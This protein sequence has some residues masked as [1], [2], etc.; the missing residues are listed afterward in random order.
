MPF[1]P[2][3]PPRSHPRPLPPLPFR[4]L[5]LAALAMALAWG[6]RTPVASPPVPPS[7]SPKPT[8]VR[9]GFTLQAG[10]FAKVEN[11]A[12]L[13]ER[14]QSE[15][16]D[17]T[18]F[19]APDGLHKVRFGDFPTREAARQRGEALVRSG[20]LETFYIVA[21]EPILQAPPEDPEGLRE[22][23]VRTARTY[24]G[25]PYLWGG[26]DPASGFDCSGLTWTTYR[27]N[28]LA[29]PRSSQAQ[30]DLGQPISD[31]E[32]RKGDLVFFA[33]GKAGRVSHVGLYLGGRRFI[34]APRQGSRIGEAALDEPYYRDRY[35]GARRYF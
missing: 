19:K 23:L 3:A 14:L 17:A 22:A 18:Y 13:A 31:A 21:P 4:T 32:L 33:T 28:G 9:L 30:W 27:M 8:L 10:A 5:L 24:L 16:L 12:R 7:T 1:R 29:L 11:A 6:C 26:A 15:G 25:L 35:L 34:H 20:T 2:S